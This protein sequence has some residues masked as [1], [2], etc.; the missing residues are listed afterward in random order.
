MNEVCST[1]LKRKGDALKKGLLVCVSL[2]FLLT[3]W[4]PVSASPVESPSQSDITPTPSTC[5]VETDQTD[6][7]NLSEFERWGFGPIRSVAFSS[8]G[9][10]FLVATPYGY[11]LYDNEK[12]DHTFKWVKISPPSE[13]LEFASIDVDDKEVCYEG[14]P[15]SYRCFEIDSGKD[16]ILEFEP[17]LEMVKKLKGVNDIELL[18]NN[19]KLIYK[20]KSKY[21]ESPGGG[22]TSEQ[23]TIEEVLNAATN[24]KKFDLGAGPE[25]LRYEERMMP[26]GCDLDSFSMCGNAYSPIPW[27]PLHAIFSPTDK[28]LGVIYNPSGLFTF[29]GR[30]RILKIYN[31]SNGRLI[32]SFGSVSEPVVDFAFD[33]KS[34]RLLIGMFNG[35][36]QLW[37]IDGSKKIWE[38]KDF[39]Q[40]SVTYRTTTDG[41]FLVYEGVLGDLEVRNLSNGKVVGK[42]ESSAFALSP[43]HNLLAIG[44]KNGLI[45][46]I[47]LDT[48]EKILE[49]HGHRKT[50][51]SLKFSPDEKKLVSS[52][53]DCNVYSWD[54][55][56]GSL[57]QSFGNISVDPY[58]MGEKYESRV[59]IKDFVFLDKSDE[60]FGFGSW[61]TVLNWDESSGKLNY[62]VSAPALDFY[63][64]MMTVNPH[65]PEGFS[66]DER[67][68]RFSIGN[69]Y[70][71]LN[72]GKPI[73]EKPELESPDK[74][75]DINCTSFGPT[76]KDGKTLFAMEKKDL[77]RNICVIDVE[78][79]KLKSTFSI[80]A[81]GEHS[82]IE[83]G[84]PFLSTDGSTLFVPTSDGVT[85]L[86]KVPD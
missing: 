25:Y 45:Q 60:L 58:E 15:I 62:H 67:S 28:Y 6:P 55:K 38:S 73:E 52:S 57:L 56:T 70:Y 12:V 37:T 69:S 39:T 41:K 29:E 14:S 34:E 48:Q 31:T 84:L 50:V 32:K 72:T 65:F 27:A 54:I 3:I 8:N 49:F 76:S 74:Y 80:F 75:D 33:P 16:I 23:T 51:Y 63:Q 46:I 26:E 47:D 24:K 11:A 59:F 1:G 81:P 2:L 17:T 44:K 35:S 85:F 18:S 68:E 83:I 78:T 10:Y 40:S 71:D 19:G 36:V 5:A 21:I 86:F 30:Y 4:I 79:G 43:V 13:G 61:G 42:Y 7:I 66:V 64:G 20:G 82:I 53:E 77:D 9:R 22:T